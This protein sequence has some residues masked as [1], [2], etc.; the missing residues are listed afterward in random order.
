MKFKLYFLAAFLTILTALGYAV[1]KNMEENALIR[2]TE[3]SM[4]QQVKM[5]QAGA[6]A[7]DSESQYLY[8]LY[9]EQRQD[10]LNAQKWYRVGA[11]RGKHGGA[12]YKLAQLYMNG[13]GV[14][15]DLNEAMKWFV[16]SAA[17]GDVRAQ[18]ILGVS[19]RDGW[20][21]QP[22]RIEAYKW[23]LLSNRDPD[24]VMAEDARYNPPVALAEMDAV[25]SRFNREIAQKRADKW[26]AR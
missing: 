17:Q 16:A 14:E 10:Y 25:M 20:E 26:R 18:F 8:G 15:N 3:M 22:D 12:Q 6:V 24:K 21:G 2:D 19:E 23:F 11:I 5:W 13:Q 9:F 4:A 7:G 1:G